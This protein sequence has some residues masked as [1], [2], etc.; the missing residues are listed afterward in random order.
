[1]GLTDSIRVGASG[2]ADGYT[3]ERSLRCDGYN[4]YLTRT[5]SSTGNRKP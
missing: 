1:M 5:P 2:V 3:I 4:G